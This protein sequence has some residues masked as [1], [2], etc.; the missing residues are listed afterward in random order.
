MRSTFKVLFYLKRNKEKTQSAVPVM[1]RITVNGTI[2]QFSA[3]L[4]VPE[5]LWEVRGGRAKGRSLEADRINRYLDNIRIQIGKHYQSICDRDG[6]VSADKVKN[7]YL[8]FSKRYKL[9][10]ELCDEFCKEYKNRID[11]DRTIHSLFRYQTLRRDLSLFICQD[12]KVKDIPLVELDQSFAE[13]FAAYLKHVRGLA[14]TTISV[15]IKSLKHIVKKA[16]NDGQMEKNPFAYYYYFADQP[17]IE[18]LTEEEINKLIIGKVKQQRQDRTRDM[19]LFCCFTGLS[20][21][22]LAKLSYEELK[23]T[24]NGAWWIS[25]IRQKTKVPFTV[26]LLP[27]AKAILEKYRIPANRFNRLFPEN[28]GKV[29]PVASLKSSDVC[30]KHIA[31]QCGITKNLKFHMARH[32]FATTLSL[33]NGIPLE[34]VSKML[35]HKYT[36][37]TQI[38]AKVTNQMIDNAISRIEDQIG[39]RFQ[40]PTLKEESDG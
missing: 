34:T 27:V 37:T 21:A 32:T 22:D 2:S 18:Y 23:Q 19:F 3:K 12:Y 24:P 6:Y 25:S 38:Y 40:C 39:E 5:R 16:F 28:P 15:E 26:K 11:V 8:G 20:Y 9:L 13:K 10:L 17:E 14:D 35:G 29:F 4:T 7:A 36:T 33:M 30:L 31:R 1:G